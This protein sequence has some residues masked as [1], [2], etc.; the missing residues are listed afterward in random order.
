MKWLWA[1]WTA[2][3]G[4]VGCGVSGVYVCVCVGG[5]GEEEVGCG[6]NGFY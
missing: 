3:D 5:G 6:G 4:G 1:L 2:S